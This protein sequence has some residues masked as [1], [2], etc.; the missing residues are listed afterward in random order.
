MTDVLINHPQ[1]GKFIEL[2]NQY[3]LDITNYLWRNRIME[4]RKIFNIPTE[5]IKQILD[6]CFFP[7]VKNKGKAVFT[8]NGIPAMSFISIKALEIIEK[9]ESVQY[10]YDGLITEEDFALF[11][12]RITEENIAWI[13]NVTDIASLK[14]L[15]LKEI[16]NMQPYKEIARFLFAF[17]KSLSKYNHTDK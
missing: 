3:I 6:N 9:K 7:D 16:F 5:F 17:L 15:I 4:K 11:K 13:P 8:I 2:Q 1:S 14:V 12:K 10:H